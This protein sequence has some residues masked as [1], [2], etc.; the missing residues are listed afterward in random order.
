MPFKTCPACGHNSDG[1]DLCP[2]CNSNFTLERSSL[3][4]VRPVAQSTQIE[5]KK[6]EAERTN[7]AEYALQWEAPTHSVPT[8]A[9]AVMGV[10]QALTG[11]GYVLQEESPNRLVF[12]SQGVIDAK[13]TLLGSLKYDAR[14]MRLIVSFTD[15]PNRTR[16]Q[17]EARLLGDWSWVSQSSADQEIGNLAK[18]CG[19]V[20]T[21]FITQAVKELGGR[22]LKYVSPP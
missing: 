15:T 8:A 16:F 12:V 21:T 17:I 2:K 10:L 20:V 14:P 18:Y 7:N 19:E 9:M 4:R 13:R 11:T 6:I 1:F 22:G 3:V 5:P